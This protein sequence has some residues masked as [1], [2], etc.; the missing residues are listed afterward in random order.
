[1]ARAVFYLLK[2]RIY[3]S[4]KLMVI[5]YNLAVRVCTS[6]ALLTELCQ[7]GVDSRSCTDNLKISY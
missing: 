5:D 7:P 4:L 3:G 1:M 6:S 2:Q